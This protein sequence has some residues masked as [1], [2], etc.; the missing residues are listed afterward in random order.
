MKIRNISLLLF[1][2]F[3]AIALAGCTRNHVVTLPEPIK[4]QLDDIVDT[5][6]CIKTESFPLEIESSRSK[7][8]FDCDKLVAAGLLTKETET[9][10]FESSGT[11]VRVTYDLTDI[12]ESA[13][14]TSGT[15]ET[16]YGTSS[17]C[18]GKPHIAK[19]TRV[20]GP[21]AFG[22]RQNLGIR[23]IVQ[24]DDP[25]P[26]VFDPRARNLGIPLPDAMMPGK[27]ALYPEQDVTAVINA[28]NPNDV[29]IDGS[30]HV[31]PAGNN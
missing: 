16:G 18:F 7:Y 12:G 10:A 9:D 1:M 22:T 29:Y 8:C 27:P 23:Y 13:Y 15:G 14:V 31:G 28:Y 20:F 11:P 5:M 4:A 25:N 21:V 30:M 17:F 6:A 3:L 2:H 19:I 26:Y 24:L